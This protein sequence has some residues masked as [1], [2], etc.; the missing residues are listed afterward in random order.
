MRVPEN[1]HLSFPNDEGKKKGFYFY[2]PPLEVQQEVL[3]RN[4]F[5]EGC[6]PEAKGFPLAYSK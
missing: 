5:L 1:P 6:Q 4:L 2:A 3:K